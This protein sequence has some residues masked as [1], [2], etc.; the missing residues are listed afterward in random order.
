VPELP[1]SLAAPP[2][3]PKLRGVSHEIAAFVMPFL[4]IVLF[5]LADTAAVRWSVV[6]YTLG[7]TA[8]YTASACY[9]RG[10][11]S[12]PVRVRLRRLDHAM[13]IVAIAATYTG[14]AVGGLGHHTTV[15][16]LTL[17]WS[18]AV[19]GVIVQLVWLH[20]P[21]WLSASV[22]I[23]LGWMAVAFTP[24]LWR[25]LGV[26]TFVLLALGGIVYSV[27]AVVYATRRPDPSP[28]VF[29]Y[30]E[31]FHVLVIVAGLLFYAAIMRVVLSS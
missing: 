25:Q 27:G 1:A 26:V 15:I 10:H 2:V 29:G 30:H 23:A 28:E 5:V 31:V 20:A 22:Y 7:L 9:H 21:R 12:A 16:L 8:M 6:V 3:K 19:V 11:W 13:I 14:I 17:A 24:T 4:G 18:L